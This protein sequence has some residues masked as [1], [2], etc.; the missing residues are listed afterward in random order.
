ME[1]ISKIYCKEKLKRNIINKSPNWT[2]KKLC[3]SEPGH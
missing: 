3:L 1:E 2:L